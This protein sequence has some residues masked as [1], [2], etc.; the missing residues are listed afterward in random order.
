L[1]IADTGGGVAAAGAGAPAAF[2]MA[3]TLTAAAPH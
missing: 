3:S 2:V 1:A